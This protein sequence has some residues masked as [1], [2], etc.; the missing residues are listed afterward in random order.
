[1]SLAK[2]YNKPI[3]IHIDQENNPFENETELL[4][5]KTIEYG[6]QGK[7]YG[8]HAISLGA[9]DESDQDRIIA[10]VREADMGIIICPSAALSMKPLP[11]KAPIHNSIA[12][13]EKLTEAG[14][15]C[16][17]GIDNIQDFFMPIV[18]GDMWTECRILMEACRYYDIEKVA[19]WACR[20]PVHL[21]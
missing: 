8:I 17:L 12:P 14:V 5:D 20:K 1:M 16:Y 18:D 19:A 13:F 7:V 6:L 15:R 3:D 4:A 9:K 21:T 10:K 2:K 11:V